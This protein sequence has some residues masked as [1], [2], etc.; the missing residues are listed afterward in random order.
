VENNTTRIDQVSGD[1]SVQLDRSEDQNHVES[2]SKFISETSLDKMHE[3]AEEARRKKMSA[4]PVWVIP[5][6]QD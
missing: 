1:D 2:A 4:P 6:W 5:D 3:I